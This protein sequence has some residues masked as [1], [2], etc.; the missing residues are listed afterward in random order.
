L[1]TGFLTS[2]GGLTLCTDSFIYSDVLL[3]ASV[4]ESN[5]GI[6][7]TIQKAPKRAGPNAYRIYVRVQS[8]S[9]VRELVIPHIHST[10]RYKVIKN[11]L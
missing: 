8:M 10:M 2:A 5:F 7:T 3:L 11:N 1:L 4:L 6:L 9:R